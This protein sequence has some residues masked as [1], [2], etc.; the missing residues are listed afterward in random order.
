[1]DQGTD[2]GYLL[3]PTKSI[4]IPDKPDEKEATKGE[5]ERAGLNINYVDGIRY[6][7]AF[8]GTRYEIEEW[9]R[10]KVEEWS[11]GVCTLAKTSKQYP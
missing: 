7:G 1:M 10:L 4:F 11:H 2:R 5:F 8:L 6:L 9:V 3:E